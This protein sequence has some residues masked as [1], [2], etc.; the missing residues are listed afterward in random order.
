[1]KKAKKTKALTHKT[2]LDRLAA[3]L[4]TALRRETKNIIENGGDAMS[5]SPTFVATFNDDETVRMTVFQGHAGLDLARG[6]RLAHHAYRSRKQTDKAPPIV[7]AHYEDSETG[8]TLKRYSAKELSARR[9]SSREI[10]N[11]FRKRGTSLRKK[12]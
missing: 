5:D 1:M 9:G 8:A 7:E 3:Q 2:A 6:I 4:R 11:V 12:P 10:E